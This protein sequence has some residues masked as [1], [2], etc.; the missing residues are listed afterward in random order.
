MSNVCPAMTSPAR[1]SAISRLRATEYDTTPP[2]VPCAPLAIVSHGASLAAV[3][4][5]GPAVS[6]VAAP[7]PPSFEKDVRSGVTVY[8]HVTLAAAWFTVTAKPATVSAPVRVEG[9]VLG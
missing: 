4:A 2:P 8:S 3:H 5:Q 6:T 9:V 1:R 7:V